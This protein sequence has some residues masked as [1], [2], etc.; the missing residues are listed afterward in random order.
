MLSGAMGTSS[1]SKCGVITPN[2]WTVSAVERPSQTW[3]VC[4]PLVRAADRVEHRESG[5]IRVAMTCRL[6]SP[7][8]FETVSLL[9]SGRFVRSG[10]VLCSDD[11]RD[12]RVSLVG[13]TGCSLRCNSIL[14]GGRRR[15]IAAGDTAKPGRS[16]QAREGNV[17]PSLAMTALFGQK[18]SSGRIQNLTSSARSSSFV[19][20]PNNG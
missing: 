2:F 12:S 8:G 1:V 14:F 7:H 20:E 16:G 5:M 15:I 13:E 17:A 9:K 18:A 3:G 19:L 4:R 11:P 10:P 6:C